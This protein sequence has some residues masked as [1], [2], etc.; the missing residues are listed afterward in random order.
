MAGSLF[1]IAYQKYL[2][3]GYLMAGSLFYIAYQKYLFGTILCLAAR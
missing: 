1:Y 2:L 3:S